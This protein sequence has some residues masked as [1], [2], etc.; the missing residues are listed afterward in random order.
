LT[1]SP[2]ALKRQNE[3]LRSLR[4]ELADQKWVFQQVL[5]SPSWRLTAPLR[6]LANRFRRRGDSLADLLRKAAE[7]E[8]QVQVPFYEP[9]IDLKD[10]FTAL[11]GI[12]LT[13]FLTSDSRIELAPAHAP[14]VSIILVLFN[15]AELTLACLRTIAGS[16]DEP[17]EVVIVDNASTDDTSRLLDRIHGARILRNSENLNFLLAVN[18]AAREC[19][20][21]YLML[22]NNDTQLVPGSIQNALNTIRSSAGIGAVGGK[23]ILLDG[24]LQEAGSVIWRDGSCIGYG[25][26]DN[27]FE[28][29]YMFRRDVDYCSAAFLLTPRKCWEELGGF[30]EIF[31][32]AYYE[33]TDYCM[34]LWE[35]GLRVVYEPT[36][37]AIHYEFASSNSTE[38]ATSLQ[39]AH[40]GVFEERHRAFL[41]NHELPGMASLIRARSRHSGRRVLLI[42][43]RAP[44]LWLGSGFP[45]AHALLTSL[46]GHGCFVTLCPLSY[47]SEPWESVYSDIPRE[48]E[49]MLGLEPNMLPVFMKSREEYYDT[50]IVSRPHNMEQLKVVLTQNPKSFENVCVIYDAEAVFTLREAG[51][52]QIS[53]NALSEEDFAAALTAEIGLAAAA[54]CVLAVS[55]AEARVFRD[56]TSCRV[57]VLGHSIEPQP[58]S[59][60]FRERAGIL[61]VGAVHEE[62]SPNGDSLVWFLSEVFPQLKQALPELKLTIAGVNKSRRIQALATQD[63][64]ITGHVPDLIPLYAQA[65][66]LIAPTRYA[67]GIP[68]KV[69]ESAAYGLPVVATSILAQQ[70]GWGPS[71][72]GIAGSAEEFVR[73]CVNTYTDENR[74]NRMRDA[75]LAKIRIEC[76][77]RVFDEKVGTLLAAV[78]P[79]VSAR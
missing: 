42:D 43:D 28:A 14:A 21:E 44:H 74:W 37:T 31:R 2:E 16:L 4:K 73:E 66:L 52:R 24:T 53:G 11:C 13:G 62:N 51:L 41:R 68:H 15:R 6:W 61:F 34:R 7:I 18:Q 50:I 38:A 77:P 60:P 35:R 75:A 19:R 57:E 79:A 1:F 25:R 8:D 40:Q 64:R 49:V 71:E 3:L 22:L 27:P 5:Q 59:T 17:F 39:A 33:E 30:A 46:L 63:V 76:S 36:A 69:H 23:L 45:R 10:S 78:K 32:P 55:E 47:I 67:A 20:G 65:R 26:G 58:T 70:L 48:V 9:S 72:L 12:S 54:G 56:N 29:A